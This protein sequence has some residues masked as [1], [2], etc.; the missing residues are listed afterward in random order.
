MGTFIITLGILAICAWVFKFFWKAILKFCFYLLEKAVDVV[1]KIITATRRAGKA[2]MYIYRRYRDGRTTKVE[3]NKHVDEE[4]VDI[5]MLPEGLQEEL[6][7]HEEVIV[8]KGDISPEE[9]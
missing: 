7:I 2:V 4:P 1:T 8:K 6:G 9:F 5:D 3:L